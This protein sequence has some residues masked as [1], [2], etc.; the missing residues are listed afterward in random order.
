MKS[1]NWGRVLI[2][3]SGGLDSTVLAGLYARQRKHLDLLTFRNGAQ[4]DLSLAKVHLPHI[5]RVNPEVSVRHVFEDVSAAFRNLVIRGINEHSSISEFTYICVGCKLVMHSAAIAYARRNGIDIVADG[6]IRGQEF[7]PEQTPAFITAI[8]R[9]YAQ[10]GVRHVSPLYDSITDKSQIRELA[11]ELNIPPRSIDGTCLFEERP[12]KA[13]N[14]A[15]SDYI[16]NKIQAFE[17]YVRK[18]IDP[19]RL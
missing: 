10:F 12:V 2:L 14:A 11:A 15:I 13:D 3:Y 8:D 7:Y 1:D 16:Q 19:F 17:E 5:K 6:F 18:R 9:L 4:Q